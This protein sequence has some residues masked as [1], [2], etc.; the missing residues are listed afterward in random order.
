MCTGSDQSCESSQVSMRRTLMR[1]HAPGRCPQS[2]PACCCLPRSR[3]GAPGQ[4]PSGCRA[5]CLTVCPCLMHLQPQHLSAGTKAQHWRSAPVSRQSCTA[6]TLHITLLTRS[7]HGA[8]CCPGLLEPRRSSD[9]ARCCPWSSPPEL[10]A[11]R[12]AITA[13]GAS[14]ASSTSLSP[15]R[16]SWMSHREACS[17]AP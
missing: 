2:W 3:S 12:A 5:C 11:R 15:T 14:A 13:S 7:G 1:C 6:A 9:W 8:N 10:E 16:A 4:R 17:R